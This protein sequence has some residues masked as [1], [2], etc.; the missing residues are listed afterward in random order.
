MTRETQGI[1]NNEKTTTRRDNKHTTQPQRHT[2]G[3]K[4]R[5]PERQLHNRTTTMRLKWPLVCC[6]I[7]VLQIH[8]ERVAKRKW[9]CSSSEV[10]PVKLLVPH[11]RFPVPVTGS[12]PDT[13]QAAGTGSNHW[14]V[15]TLLPER[16]PYKVREAGRVGVV[17]Q[18]S[19]VAWRGVVW[20]DTWAAFSTGAWFVWVRYCCVGGAWFVWRC[21][22]PWR[23]VV[24]WTKG[25][26]FPENTAPLPAAAPLSSH[27]SEHR[28]PPGCSITRTPPPPRHC[29]WGASP[30]SRARTTRWTQFGNMAQ[31]NACLKWTFTVFNVLFAVSFTSSDKFQTCDVVLLN[32]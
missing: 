13:A 14:D 2:K 30:V 12:C 10:F 11:F 15:S 21:C 5:K 20:L 29:C 22:C 17:C 18:N 24:C 26:T 25:C 23:G 16:E 6:A 3:P 4:D 1:Q 31:I 32:T 9:T 7:R 19:R 8:V 28:P 27:L